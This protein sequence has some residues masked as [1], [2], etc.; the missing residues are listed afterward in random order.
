[1][2]KSRL[3]RYP[4]YIA[5]GLLLQKILQLLKYAGLVFEPYYF[6]Q[7]GLP[8]SGP[9]EPPEGGGDFEFEEVG[10]EFFSKVPPEES[11]LPPTGE[12]ETRFREG[13]RCFALKQGARMVA[14]SWCNTT[15]ITFEPC[16]RIL[17]PRE[18]Y[19]YGAETLFEF[20]GLRLQPYLRS[21]C[22][23]A[24]LGEGRG[25]VYS[26]SDYFNYPARRFKEK[27]GA[28][29]LFIGLH[30]RMFG[31]W[32]WNTVLRRVGEVADTG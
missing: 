16:G 7:E 13:G 28:R 22:Y 24:L 25:I 2:P 20:R 29:I 19:L 8:G 3:R 21:R 4:T 11:L 17:G 14:Y 1:M 27:L 18:A 6:Y 23:Q 30:V 9:E 26:Y 10:R 5:R 12:L 32:K 15:R 31:K